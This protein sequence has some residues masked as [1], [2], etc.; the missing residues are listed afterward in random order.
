MLDE[1][2]MITPTGR[3]ISMLARHELAIDVGANV[4]NWTVELAKTF[5]RVVAYEPDRRAINLI[6]Q[7]DNVT[8]VEA[9][10]SNRGGETSLYLRPDTGQNSLLE[11][12]PIGGG[13][14]S[15]APV[16][17]VTTVSSVTLDSQHPDGA[18]FVKI[19]VEG[20]EQDVLAGCSAGGRWSRT[21]F[22]V[23]CHDTRQAVVEELWRL[24][25]R[26]ELHRHPLHGAHPGHCWLIGRP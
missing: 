23:E 9:A 5:T 4:G 19:D 22:V 2:W 10:V 16:E 18:D 14:Q 15:P 1:Q 12:H 6:P 13:G 24:G 26:V 7:I 11:D 21:V 25:K 3:A 20:A 17:A 8:I